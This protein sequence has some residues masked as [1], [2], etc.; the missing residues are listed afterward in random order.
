MGARVAIFFH[1]GPLDGRRLGFPSP[2]PD[3]LV[4]AE[5]V[6]AT[7]PEGQPGL[8]YHDYVVDPTRRDLRRGRLSGHHHY[9]W[10]PR[11]KA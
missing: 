6:P 7:T 5:L 10:A 2:L 9:V 4:M 8:S 3:R 11:D 1:G